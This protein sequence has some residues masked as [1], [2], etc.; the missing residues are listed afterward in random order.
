MHFSAVPTWR[1]LILSIFP[2]RTDLHDLAN[3]WLRSQN[4]EQWFSKSSWSLVSIAHL[5][6]MK[7]TGSEPVIWIPDYFCNSA[8]TPLRAH[9]FSLTFYPINEDGE[10][11]YEKCKSMLN[12]KKIDIFIYVHYFGRPGNVVKAADFCNYAKSWLVEDSSHVFLPTKGI[13]ERGDF[14]LYSQHKHFPI[15]NGALMVINYKGIS[16]VTISKQELNNTVID[17][18]KSP[19]ID[20]SAYLEYLIWFLKKNLQKLGFR[21][22]YVNQFDSDSIKETI[23]SPKF[24]PLSSRMLAHCLRSLPEVINRKRRNPFKWNNLLTGVLGMNYQESY[25]S[26][27]IENTFLRYMPAY[28]FGSEAGKAYSKLQSLGLPVSSWP[29]LPPEVL[30]DPSRYRH[31]V[32]LRNELIFLSNHQSLSFRKILRSKKIRDVVALKLS[33]KKDQ[34]QIKRAGREEWEKLFNSIS[35]SNILQD[36]DYGEVK[37]N[38]QGWQ[39]ERFIIYEAD[40]P[41]CLFQ[42]LK[43]KLG[44][45]KVVRINRGPLLCG[46]RKTSEFSQLPY[47]IS[48]YF[49]LSRGNILFWNPEFPFNDEVCLSLDHV[50][51]Q[52]QNA[53]P[54]VSSKIDLTNEISFIRK[55]LD[56][57]WRNML[58]KAESMSLHLEV[59]DNLSSWPWL[60]ERYSAIMLEKGFSGIPVSLVEELISLKTENKKLLIL[61]AELNNEK[62]ASVCVYLHGKSCTYL[63]GWSGEPGRLSN[64][65][66]FLLWNAVI[67]LKKR[68]FHFFD[69]GGIDY[70]NTPGIA[71]FKEGMNGR[72]YELSGEYLNV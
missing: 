16:K 61:R 38:V 59:D 41:L 29:D 39:S 50:L 49:K 36:W 11:D 68:N 48:N 32:R 63:I 51:K 45:F 64:A 37:E 71:K 52:R 21:K 62:V 6:K 30:S 3:P 35:T 1:N 13:G 15:F 17:I 67:E 44:L 7:K 25:F 72:L 26:E 40:D 8:L 47:L 2:R 10:P 66:H 60:K 14:V 57:K 34:F 53:A 22:T 42:V 46:N 12:G 5:K 33:S 56:G 4:S 43:K 27:S 69:L 18:M 54:W 55:S 70:F 65:K 28:H 19:K 31:A 23:S 58:K 24:L 20:K 9:G